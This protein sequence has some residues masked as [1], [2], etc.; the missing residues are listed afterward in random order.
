M[1]IAKKA[2]ENMKEKS[3]TALKVQK[4]GMIYGGG[5]ESRPP[6]RVVSFEETNRTDPAADR[7]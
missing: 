1:Q 5:L 3:R 2:S 6:H 4:F 7:L